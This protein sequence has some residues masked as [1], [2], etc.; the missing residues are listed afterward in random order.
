MTTLLTT[1]VR[2]ACYLAKHE[3]LA[4]RARLLEGEIDKLMRNTSW[5]VGTPQ[6]NRANAE[7]FLVNQI[8]ENGH[9]HRWSN[10]NHS[11]FQRLS[12]IESKAHGSL[13]MECSDEDLE[14]IR[15]Y[16]LQPAAADQ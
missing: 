5:S 3:I 12:E 11:T 14:Y 8:F 7:R 15:N 13:T 16:V 10:W 2:T 4:E 6:I 1:V 9:V